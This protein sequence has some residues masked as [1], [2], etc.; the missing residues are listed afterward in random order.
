[1]KDHPDRFILLRKP[2]G[3]FTE[4]FH[5]IQQEYKITPYVKIESANAFVTQVR[6][7]VDET[8]ILIFVNSNINDS[9]EIKITPASDM[10][11]GKQSWV[12]DPETGE[13]S[14]LMTNDQSITLDMGPADLKLIIFDNEKQGP[15]YQPASVG[16]KQSIALKNSW[17]LTGQH[18]D[19][20]TVKD[21]SDQ[22]RDLKDVPQWTHFCGSIVY[23][24][25]FEVKDV[26]KIEWMN[27]G[28]VHGVSELFI[29]GKKVGTMWYGRRIYS[30]KNFLKNG[31][32]DL[33]VKITT[34]MG[35]YLKSLADNPIA[36]FW[37]NQGRTI[38]PVQ[39]I[40]LV[41][42]VSIY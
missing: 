30:V 36:Q 21:K 27:L 42:P 15:V 12:W 38:Q 6:Y 23:R 1:M 2:A 13:R 14:R 8:E 5:S 37:T 16:G 28:K 17:S 3:D 41:G 7:Q 40:G 25:N 18:I 24:T 39:S 10:T 20:T 34:T 31:D 19:G 32:N 4:W 33:Q 9:H 26:S 35:N 29:N 22:L 11:L